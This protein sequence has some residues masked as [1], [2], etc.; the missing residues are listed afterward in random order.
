MNNGSVQEARRL[1]ETSQKILITSHIRPDGDAIGS[2]L[3]LGL[4]LQAAGKDVQMIL[5]DGLPKSFRHLTGSEQ[6]QKRAKDIYECSIVVDCSDLN[7]AGKIFLDA[8]P[9]D[10]NIDHLIGI[11]DQVVSI[12]SHGAYVYATWLD[13]RQWGG[14]GYDV[15]TNV[16]ADSGAT[17]GP[18]QLVNHGSYPAAIQNTKPEI[19]AGNGYVNVFWADPRVW[20]LPNIYTNYSTDNGATWG[21]SYSSSSLSWIR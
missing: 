10:I 3:G 13:S 9:P 6:I 18:E 12:Q 21:N 20:G 4:A 8:P 11:R 1:I 15:F 17:W 2:V 16:S 5:E 14:G 19:A 7:R